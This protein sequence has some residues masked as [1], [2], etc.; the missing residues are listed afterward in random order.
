M[1]EYDFKQTKPG[2]VDKYKIFLI[3]SHFQHLGVFGFVLVCLFVF[4]VCKN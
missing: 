3:F 1:I 4:N 2:S